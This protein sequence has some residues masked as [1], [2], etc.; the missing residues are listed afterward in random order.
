MAVRKFRPFETAIPKLWTAFLAETGYDATLEAVAMDLAELH[1]SILSKRGLEDGDWDIA[2]LSTDWIAEALHT[3]ALED[4]SSRIK[5]RPPQGFPEGWPDSLLQMQTRDSGIFGLPFH[6]GPECLIY[7]KDLM[8]DA[9][10]RSRFF[11]R[12]ARELVPP[13]DWEE[14]SEVAAFFRQPEKT[15]QGAIL[16]AFPDGHNAVFDFCIQ[17]WSRGG[18]LTDDRG[19]IRLESPEAEE[20]LRF[21]RRLLG[22]GGELSHACHGYDSVRAG[23]AFARG[24]AAMMVNWFGFAAFADTDASSRVKGLVDVAPLPEGR[25]GKGVSLNSYWIYAITSGS[26]HQ[27]LAYEFIRFAV[28]EAADRLLTLEGGIGCRKSSWKDSLINTQ[29]PYYHKLEQLHQSARCLPALNQWSRIAEVIDMVMSATIHS[30]VPVEKILKMGQQ[31]L[32][33]HEPDYTHR[34]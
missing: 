7:R 21:Y 31:K 32:R 28:S 10:N 6:D 19:D 11:E 12:F 33:A 13:R 15:L 4:L 30:A 16:A 23:Q 14:F 29:I 8:E 18:E 25:P 5:Q 2:H 24:E 3:G 22:E 17:L 20:A 9:T 1:D 26:R 34:L 27:Q